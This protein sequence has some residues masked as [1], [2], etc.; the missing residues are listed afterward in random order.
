MK[1]SDQLVLRLHRRLVHA[2]LGRDMLR[3]Q[4]RQ[5][6]QFEQGCS[7]VLGQIALSEQAKAQELLV[8]LPEV[9]EVR[10]RPMIATLSRNLR[11]AQDCPMR[12]R[13]MQLL[14]MEQ[15]SNRTAARAPG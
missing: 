3:E 5:L 1:A 6:A 13:I 10:P 8:M 14:E 9:G 12:Q 2:D 15:K 7:R 4:L 11:H